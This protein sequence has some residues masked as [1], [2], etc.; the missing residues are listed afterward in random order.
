MKTAEKQMSESLSI[1]ILLAIVGGF[2]DAYTYISRGKVFA[3]AQTGN[4]VLFG[5]SLAEGEFYKASLYFVPILAFATGIFIS[6]LIRDKYKKNS[7]YKLHW[8]QL[9]IFIELILLF[10]VSFVKQGDK[11]IIVNVIV[12]FV[13]S[14]QVESF[15]KLR[16]KAYATTMCTGNL[17]SATASLVQYKD[18]KDKEK[19]KVSI[20]YYTIILF[21][22]IGASVGAILTNIFVEK[23]VIFCCIILLMIFICLYSE[24]SISYKIRNKRLNKR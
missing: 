13:C 6:D 11:D 23:S 1:G 20:R 9:V 18:T 17:R 21:F 5:V 8:R 22:I 14:L 12:S 4:I 15:R 10:C 16:G 24:T 2:L 3:N 19:M 7:E